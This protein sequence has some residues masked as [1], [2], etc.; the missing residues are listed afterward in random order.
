VELETLPSKVAVI[1]KCDWVHQ[2]APSVLSLSDSKADFMTGKW[3]SPKMAEGNMPRF[4]RKGIP[5]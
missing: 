4:V 2:G 1:G 3:R 5:E